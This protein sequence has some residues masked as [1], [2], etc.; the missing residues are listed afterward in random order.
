MRLPPRNTLAGRVVR[1]MNG[2]RWTASGLA[3]VLDVSQV[4]VAKTLSDMRAR[5]RV[6]VVGRIPNGAN[7]SNLYELSPELA[8]VLDLE[9]SHD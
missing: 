2:G 7:P 3:E 5:G 9:N 8:S 1:E 4:P 6:L